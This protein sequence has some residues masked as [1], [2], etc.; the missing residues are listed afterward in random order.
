MK[1]HNL[2]HTEGGIQR[3]LNS[4]PCS[5]LETDHAPTSVKLSCSLPKYVTFNFLFSQSIS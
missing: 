3:I 2:H 4:M 5:K 1:K